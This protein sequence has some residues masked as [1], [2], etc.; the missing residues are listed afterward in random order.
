MKSDLELS[1][2]AAKFFSLSSDWNLQEQFVKETPRT[3]SESIIFRGVF[4]FRIIQWQKK[5]LIKKC[6]MDTVH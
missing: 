6:P 3:K 5:F 1:L 2:F 4:A